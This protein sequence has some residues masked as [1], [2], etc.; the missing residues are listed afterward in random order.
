MA[1]SSAIA[2]QSMTGFARSS[3]SHNGVTLIWELRSVNGK[4]LEIRL[5]LPPGLERLEQTIRQTIQ[6]RFSRGNMQVSLTLN[7]GGAGT[8][9]VINEALL[10]QA[11][12]AA[13]RLEQEFGALPSSS[14]QLLSLRGIME[15]GE[16]QESDEDRTSFDKSCL[17]AL[18]LALDG[19]NDARGQEGQALSW[20]LLEQLDR[21]ALLVERAENDPSRSLEA[22]RAR[23]ANQVNLLLEASPALDEGRLHMEAAFLATK[24]DIREELDRLAMHVAAARDLLAKGGP[25]GRKLDFIAQEFNREANTLCSKSNSSAITAIGLELKVVVDQYREQIQNLE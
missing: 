21:I 19:L 4:T 20:I 10:E 12:L 8:A 25:I 15:P 13:K 17:E 7:R 2:V 9:P 5:R 16:Q 3:A 11:M 1:D 6:K 18:A 22:I 24:A 14:A 23:L